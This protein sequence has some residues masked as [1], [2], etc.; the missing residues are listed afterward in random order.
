MA[1]T[2][3]QHWPGP[4]AVDMA[5]SHIV[6]LNDVYISQQVWT[7]GE[8]LQV[9]SLLQI[10]YTPTTILIVTPSGDLMVLE[11]HCEGIRGISSR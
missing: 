11:G 3:S 7:E 4:N 1:C 5:W 10:H 6:E 2:S 9:G 8:P